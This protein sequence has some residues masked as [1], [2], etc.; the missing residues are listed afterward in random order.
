MYHMVS[1]YTTIH[2]YNNMW[3]CCDQ[4]SCSVA[5][6]CNNNI[7]DGASSH[8]CCCHS[9][10]LLS[11]WPVVP[12]LTRSWRVMVTMQ[13]HNTIPTTP[14]VML[15][16]TSWLCLYCT[17]VC[18][19]LLCKKINTFLS[20]LSLNLRNNFALSTYDVLLWVC[21]LLWCC[22]C[23]L[24]YSQHLPHRRYKIVSSVEELQ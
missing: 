3:C 22:C 24:L 17:G 14:S 6:R 18:H 21:V 20:S 5:V 16:F 8:W 2:Q 9:R 7:G 12:V 19:T 15:T 4:C 1:I 10:V 23:V 13:L 11:L